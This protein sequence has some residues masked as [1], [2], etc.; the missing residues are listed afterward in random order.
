MARGT[1][2]LTGKTHMALP[3]AVVA[4][5]LADLEL[6]TSGSVGYLQPLT[7]IARASGP[8]VVAGLLLLGMIAGLF[9]DL[10]LQHLPCGVAE[11][12]GRKAVRGREAGEGGAPGEVDEHPLPGLHSNG[13]DARS[14]PI[15]RGPSV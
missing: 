3:T 7:L 15:A 12:L 9:P 13:P 2:R 8:Y 11:H 4:T 1:D 14:Y 10:E 5:A 6:C